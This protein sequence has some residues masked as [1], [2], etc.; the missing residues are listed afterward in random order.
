MPPKPR[1]EWDDYYLAMAFLVS[2]R[3]LD[4]RTK[5]GTVLVS[6]DNRPLA[7]G[8]NGPLKGIDD[9]TVPLESPAKYYYFLHSEENA[10]LS[11]SGSHADVQGATAYVTGEPCHKCLRMMIQ[12]GITRVCHGHVGSV[13]LAEADPE[14][15][16]CKEAM[17]QQSGIQVERHYNPLAIRALLL[18]TVS[19]FD[20]KLPEDWQWAV[21]NMPY[22]TIKKAA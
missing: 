21:D 17:V 7:T 16:R 6:K 14:E 11:Y 12:R 19:W 13:M 8:Y 3:S 4:P 2:Q 10:L 1:P 9:E 22:W 5:H 15:K 20:S 18:Q